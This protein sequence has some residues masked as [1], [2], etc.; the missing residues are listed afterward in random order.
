MFRIP[1]RWLPRTIIP[2]LRHMYWDIRNGISNIIRWVPVI[3]F[4][5]WIDWTCL[6]ILM[7]E[8]LFEMA[9]Q[10]KKQG[11]LVSAEKT[12]RNTLICATLLKRLR[13]DKYFDNCRRPSDYPKAERIAKYDQ[14]YCFKLMGKHLRSWWD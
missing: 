8:K 7:E 9:E 13:E 12:A 14:E 11:C 10:Y 1:Y 3:W 5:G 4:D 2:N 6:T